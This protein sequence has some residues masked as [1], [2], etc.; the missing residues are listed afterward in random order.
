MYTFSS[1]Q[2]STMKHNKNVSNQK[3][4]LISDH[5]STIQDFEYFRNNV[6]YLRI[7]MYIFAI[8]SGVLELIK[9]PC[10]T[11]MFFLK[12]I[13]III[14]RLCQDLWDIWWKP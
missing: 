2:L 6:E 10:Y 3:K 13:I 8:I 12:I 9:S 7:V 5:R 1:N 4:F 14:I 11:L